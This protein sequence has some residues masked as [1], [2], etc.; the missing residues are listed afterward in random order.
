MRVCDVVLENGKE[1]PPL[2]GFS[3]ASIYTFIPATYP[4]VQHS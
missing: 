1:K 3:F 2:G 4:V